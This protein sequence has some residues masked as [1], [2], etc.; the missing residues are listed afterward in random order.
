[1]EKKQKKSKNKKPLFFRILYYIVKVFVKKYQ[2]VFLEELKNDG[3]TIIVSNHA[4]AGGPLAYQFYYPRKKKIWCIGEVFDKKEFPDYAMK[5]F[6][7]HKKKSKWVYKILAHILAPLSQYIF[8]NA[9]T[10]PVYR[11]NRYFTT[12]KL[13]VNTLKNNEDIIIM[14]E[15]HIPYNEIVNEFLQN[16]VSVAKLYQSKEKKNVYFYPSYVCP[17]L[18]K[19]LIGKPILFDTEQDYETEKRR[20]TDTLKSEI[21]KLAYTLP[22]HRVVPYENINK[23]NYPHT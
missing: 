20:I 22:P 15:E 4:Q 5:D 3:A 12:A 17:A 13:S 23:K 10:L 6:W 7:P 14:P 2:F 11:D 16:F 18:K 21:T 9:D 1:M 8:K 19:V